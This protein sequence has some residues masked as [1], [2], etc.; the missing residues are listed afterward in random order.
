MRSIVIM[1]G[2]PGAGKS[3]A[4]KQLF[5][6]VTT[7]EAIIHST[8][9]HFIVNGVYEFK[10]QFLGRYHQRN[11]AEAKV[12]M[13]NGVPLVIIDNTNIKRKDFKRYVQAA[14]ANGYEVTYKE[15][16]SSQWLAFRHL[17]PVRDEWW[18]AKWAT[19]LSKCC[20]HDVPVETIARMLMNWQEVSA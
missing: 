6:S 10:P 1:R 3:Y 16:T 15:P 12:S 9:S 20:V 17:L 13:E 14:E 2:C 4:A 8:D 11:L 7:G 19:L 18:A 5:D